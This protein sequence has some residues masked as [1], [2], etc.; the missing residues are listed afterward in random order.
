[1]LHT[2]GKAL[3]FPSSTEANAHIACL[4]GQIDRR[5]A[6]TPICDLLTV[7]ISGSGS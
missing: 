3:V 6:S 2:S 4:N 5:G 1:V 7:T